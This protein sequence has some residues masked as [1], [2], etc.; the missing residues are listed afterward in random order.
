MVSDGLGGRSPPYFLLCP[1]E[2]Y[3]TPN[4]RDGALRLQNR[5][6]IWVDGHISSRVIEFFLTDWMHRQRI[7]YVRVSSFDQNPECQLDHVQVD[8]LFT[9][10][11][12]GTD[13]QSSSLVTSSKPELRSPSLNEVFLFFNLFEPFFEVQDGEN[14]QCFAVTAQTGNFLGDRYAAVA[15]EPVL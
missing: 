9:D 2:V 3:P 12:S 4:V 7:G 13:R 1:V 10:E 14:C 15:T 5:V 11:A 6:L 8:R